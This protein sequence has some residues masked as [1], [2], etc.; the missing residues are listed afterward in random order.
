[1]KTLL[2]SVLA[3]AALSLPS[4]AM[5]TTYEL[6][7]DHTTAYFVAKHMMVTNV[8]GEFGNVKGTLE[9]NEKDITK[10]TVSVTIDA[11][12]VNSGNAG[13]DTHLRGKDFFWVDK[14]PVITFKSKKVEVAGEGKLKV[15]GDLTIR[16]VTKEVVLDVDGPSK[17]IK[18]P[19]GNMRV[20]T[21]ATTT[22]NRKDFGL[23]WNVALE[24]GGVLVGDEVKISLE[25]EGVRKAAT[26]ANATAKDTK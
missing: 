26:P 17:E 25:A 8:R 9:L 7:S 18:D 15:T 3:V 11:K 1:M 16:D 22:V 13:R 14:Y 2:K 24:A 12:G 19:R 20:G 23:N 6:D 10:S 5:A 4:L 21:T